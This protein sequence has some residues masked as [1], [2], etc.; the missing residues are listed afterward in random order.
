MK[1]PLHVE[2]FEE[3]AGL[4][5]E[6][7]LAI[8]MFDG[9][10]LG[11][12]A[13]IESAVFSARR[14]GGVSGVLTFDPHPSRLFRPEAPTRMIMAIESKLTI[15]NAHGV[16]IVICK[17][18]DHAFASISAEDFLAELQGVLPTLK[19]IYVGE[20]F[21]FG[22]MRAGS[23]ATLIEFGNRLGI[24]I[25]SVERIKRNGEPISSTR[26][27]KEL[28]A[29]RIEIV[30]DL[31]G[32]NYRSDGKVVGGK[33]LGR[34]I[35]FPTLNVCWSPE[36]RPKY[37]VYHVRFRSSKE[38]LWLPGVANYGIRPTVEQ[39]SRV[40]LLEVH[41]LTGTKVDQ[42]DPI[43]VEWLHFIRPEQKFESIELLKEQIAKDCELARKLANHHG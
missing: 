9:V 20:N 30:N 2:C 22:K 1:F 27:R 7:H 31:L 17:Q 25:F 24:D 26:I 43:E 19:S 32:Y 15:L 42:G 4:T 21:H 13:V 35:G 41:A 38:E 39:T 40:P 33:K 12:T 34:K 5:S 8:G 37:G 36:C 14:S 6:L 23:V 29:G 3:L 11:H 18:F 16:D 10:H 28:E